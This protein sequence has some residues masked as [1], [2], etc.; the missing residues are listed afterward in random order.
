MAGQTVPREK[1]Q[2][3]KFGAIMRRNCPRCGGDTVV[4][5]EGLLH[6]R[7]CQ[8]TWQ[9]QGTNYRILQQR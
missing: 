2:Y 3:R 1:P 4:T 5:K 6:C 9:S 8:F 7:N